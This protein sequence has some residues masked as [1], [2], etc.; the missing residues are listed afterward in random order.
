MKIDN[1]K[2][3]ASL[4][5]LRV[6]AD[7]FT[8]GDLDLC[9]QQTH[10]YDSGVRIGSESDLYVD[11]NRHLCA[12]YKELEERAAT[13]PRD[14]LHL[15]DAQLTAFQLQDEIRQLEVKIFGIKARVHG[16]KEKESHAS[17]PDEV[18]ILRYGIEALAVQ[19]PGLDRALAAAKERLSEIIRNFGYT[20]PTAAPATPAPVTAKTKATKKTPVRTSAAKSRRRPRS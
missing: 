8:G 2:W 19:I 13:K 4:I 15:R 9:R 17:A 10:I 14:I 3:Y 7:L 6:A 11:A 1:A 18:L 20:P 16:L 5:P 12:Q